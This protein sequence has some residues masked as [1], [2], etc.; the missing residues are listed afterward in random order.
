MINS[1][2][3][4]GSSVLKNELGQFLFEIKTWNNR[5][6]DI[7]VKMPGYLGQYESFIFDIVKEKIS[8]GKVDVFIKWEQNKETMPKFEVNLPALRKLCSDLDEIKASGNLSFSTDVG[9]LLLIPGMTA[10]ITPEISEE[11]IKSVF[12]EGINNALKQVVITR[13]DEGKKLVSALGNILD[14]VD[15]YLSE[16]E[17]NKDS[18]ITKYREKLIEKINNLASSD[19]IKINEG[20]LEMEVLYYAERSDITEEI[21]R[22]KAHLDSF[23]LY[24]SGEKNEPVGKA[25]DFLCQELLREANTIGSKARDCSIITNVLKIKNEIEKIREQVQNLE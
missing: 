9:S 10:S 6:I 18:V 19:D 16:I 14:N 4:F 21:I 11:K 3:G 2:T 25:L 15:S 1:M 13:R 20:R 12:S 8:R 22:L 5:F 24:L 7:N 23:K 17:S